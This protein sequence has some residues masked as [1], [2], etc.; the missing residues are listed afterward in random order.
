M[1]FEKLNFDEI[2][3]SLQACI[4]MTQYAKLATIIAKKV[5][6]AFLMSMFVMEECSAGL[7]KDLKGQTE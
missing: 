4:Q 5:E 6:N 7:L 2:L 1:D 3:Q